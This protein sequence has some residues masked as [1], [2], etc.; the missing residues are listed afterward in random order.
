MHLISGMHGLER[1]I[2]EEEIDTTA[3]FKCFAPQ[4]VVFL[5][6]TGI[7]PES[8]EAVVVMDLIDLFLGQ[9]ILL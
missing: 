2:G 5:C 1:L 9:K 8:N 6:F 4:M 7:E 3:E